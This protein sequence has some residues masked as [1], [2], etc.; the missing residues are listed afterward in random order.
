MASDDGLRY[1]RVLVKLETP[2]WR[3]AFPVATAIRRSRWRSGVS[4]CGTNTGL[5]L[6]NDMSVRL[7]LLYRSMLAVDGITPLQGSI[8]GHTELNFAP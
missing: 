2:R 5:R 1:I 4:S 3:V 8:H 7:L 6:V